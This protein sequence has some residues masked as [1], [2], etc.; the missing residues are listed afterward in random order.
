MRSKKS[1]VVV[2]KTGVKRDREE[3]EEGQVDEDGNEHD[4]GMDE[5]G[6]IHEQTPPV[7]ESI[8]STTTTTTT[9]TTETKAIVAYPDSD[10][11]NDDNTASEGEIVILE[12]EP[13]KDDNLKKPKGQKDDNNNN[14]KKKVSTVGRQQQAAIVPQQT[15]MKMKKKI[16]PPA[17]TTTQ[18]GKGSNPKAQR[19]K[20]SH[21]RD[22]ISPPISLTNLRSFVTTTSSRPP[23]SS[24]P[25][26]RLPKKLGINHMDLL[27]KT[28]REVMVCRICLW[29]VYFILFRKRMMTDDDLD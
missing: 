10:D 12:R 7:H 20:R 25:Q 15:E 5:P 8:I 3:Y 17:S 14:N 9:T 2:S 13:P 1:S 18:T 24:P 11:D 26:P 21:Y 27:Y 19:G 16:P 23:T 4:V 6:I 29:V 28:E 22:F